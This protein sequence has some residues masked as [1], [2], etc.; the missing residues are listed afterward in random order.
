MSS[1]PSLSD[2]L[3]FLRENQISNYFQAISLVILVYDY[4]ITLSEEVALIWTAPWTTARVLF[5]LTRYSAWIDTSLLSIVHFAKGGH[6]S[7]PACRALYKASGWF[8]SIGVFIAEL[9]LVFRTYALWNKSMRVLFGLFGIGFPIT[10]ASLYATYKGMAAFMFIQVPGQQDCLSVSSL[11]SIKIFLLD[12]SG[13][14]I[15]ETIILILTVVS[16]FK[17]SNLRK[18]S[19]GET[20][21]KDGLMYYVYLTLFTVANLLVLAVPAVATSGASLVLLQRVIHSIVTSHILL[22][23]RRAGAQL[24]RD[25]SEEYTNESS[26]NKFRFSTIFLGPLSSSEQTDTSHES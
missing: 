3:L 21:Y 16:A 7:I 12:F 15:F 26:I 11:V 14:I 4:I 18:T 23:I 24:H 6:L 22:H 19:L 20:L 8:L 1:L 9:V 25:D 13:V 2:N 17:Q 5:F 10:A